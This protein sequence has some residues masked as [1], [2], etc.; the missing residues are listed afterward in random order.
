MI[1]EKYKNVKFLVF[2]GPFED[3]YYNYF[4][5]LNLNNLRVARGMDL[6]KSISL[7]SKCNFFISADSGLSH[8]A[9]LFKIPQITMFGP[10][11][12]KYIQPFSENCKVVVPDN[13]KPFYI[14]HCGFISKPYD[15]MENLKPE[16]VFNEFEGHLRKS[17][18]RIN[19]KG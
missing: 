4:N 9:S 6:R 12:Y 16:K 8:C 10:V 19:L 11:D 3:E 14:P 13:Y 5:N 2:I 15:C 18:V 7:I 1:N 17:D